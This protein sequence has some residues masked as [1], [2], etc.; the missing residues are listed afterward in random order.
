MTA[1]VVAL[2]V[3]AWALACACTEPALPIAAAP[4]LA[5]PEEV[6]PG[7]E[8][9]APVRDVHDASQPGL[10]RIAAG[11]VKVQVRGLPP[12]ALE[13]V[14]ALL[15]E[16]TGTPRAQR[17]LTRPPPPLLT[18]EHVPAGR[19]WLVHGAAQTS[20]R[21][22]YFQRVAVEIAA[23]ETP[24]VRLDVRAHRLVLRIPPRT[25]SDDD[26]SSARPVAVTPL[27]RRK[28]DPDWRYD[29]THGGALPG[30]ASTIAAIDRRTVQEW[31]IP[32]LG[33]GEYEL[34]AIGLEFA[35]APVT[36]PAPDGVTLQPPAR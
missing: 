12:A 21:T 14:V 16:R 31:T 13:T 7:L 24:T 22:S 1:L 4:P 33:A 3:A 32:H 11:S 5:L 18:F 36:L 17:A 27:L 15:D 30:K 35:P 25:A 10:G 28:D 6:D 8:R 29:P 9:L 20:L 34:E 23:G 26:P 19:Y 2:L